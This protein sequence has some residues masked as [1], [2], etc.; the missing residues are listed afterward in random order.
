[1]AWVGKNHALQRSKKEGRVMA[2][3]G[4]TPCTSKNQEGGK[5]YGLGEKDTMHFKEARRREGG[6]GFLPQV[7]LMQFWIENTEYLKFLEEGNMLFV[8]FLGISKGNPL[9]LTLV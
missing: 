4:K 2:W 6:H 3:E 5:V 7:T 9:P 8:C 1:M